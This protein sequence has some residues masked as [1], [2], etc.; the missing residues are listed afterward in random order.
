[1]NKIILGALNS[2]YIQSNLAVYELQAYAKQSFDRCDI[3]I[4]E[5]TIN[6]PVDEIMSDLY[7]RHPDIIAF[8]CYVWNISEIYQVTE[9]VKKIMPQ[10]LIILSG[11]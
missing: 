7:Q 1:M 6:Q 10:M 9:E 2:K 5:Y 8:S 4:C 11:P 3:T